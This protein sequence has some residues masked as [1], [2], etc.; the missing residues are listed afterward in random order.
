MRGLGIKAV[1]VSALLVAW[2]AAGCGDDASGPTDDAIAGRNGES[3]SP[4]TSGASSGAG[5]AQNLGGNSVVLPTAGRGG[6]SGF[7]ECA[8]EVVSGKLVPLDMFIMLDT[9]GS[10]LDVT[11]AGEE[12]WTAV[13]DALVAFLS[14]QGSSGLGV[15]I[16]YFPQRMPGVPA[17]CTSDAQCGDGGPCF[18]KACWDSP[19]EL[20]LI[21]CR[22]TADCRFS[23]LQDYGE[24]LPFGVCA[25]EPTYVCANPGPTAQCVGDGGESFG[26]CRVEPSVCLNATECD[27]AAYA[28]PAVPISVLPQAAASLVTSI[29]S[30]EPEGLT[31]TGPALRGAID[32]ARQW[33][34]SHPDHVVVTVLAT[35]G[36]PTECIP[37]EVPNVANLAAEGVQG[38]PSIRTFV[39]GVFGPTD[40]DAPANLDALA[41]S[42]GTESA[43]IVDTT[44]DVTGQFLDALNTIRG[45]LL[46]C[47]FQIPAPTNGGVLDYNLVN[48][49]LR[50]GATTMPLFFAGTSGA[51]CGA[52]G[53]WHYDRD[54]A[55]SAPSRIVLCPSTCQ[56]LQ[57]ATDAS[58]QIQLGCTTRVR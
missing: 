27:A 51:A 23:V 8:G 21:P 18:L 14:D 5:R 6:G 4:A 50:T 41:R 15:G 40:A 39:I 35:D 19:P 45:E 10:M 33:A 32:Q 52:E 53:G 3:G 2:L 24:C 13:K 7:E 12:K 30:R 49:E 29:E 55:A 1:A 43:F 54:P 38:A 42:G 56:S 20:G 31:P 22:T 16:Q 47:D 44:Q 28:A 34:T 25:D 26:A 17:E 11:E 58:V 9:S 37:V 57:A 46:S 36:L 48:V